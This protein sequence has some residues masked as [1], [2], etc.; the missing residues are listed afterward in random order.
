MSRVVLIKDHQKHFFQKI[1]EKSKLS[2]SDLGKIVGISGRS[3]R[4]WVNAKTLPTLSGIS[5]LSQDFNVLL[6]KII[7]TREEN[8]SGRV[9]GSKAVKTRNQKYMSFGTD[10]GR[11]KSGM[12]SQLNRRE[13]PDYYKKL[14]CIV[15]N[16]FR[17]PL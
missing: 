2:S 6:P 8:W 5:K 7:E 13:K 15:A 4:D 16:R 12:V 1:K 14:G 3:Y 11:K 17:T 10:E 9:N